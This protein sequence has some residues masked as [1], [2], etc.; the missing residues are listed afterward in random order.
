L[1]FLTVNIGFVIV[2]KYGSL[3]LSTDVPPDSH[4]VAVSVVAYVVAVFV[5]PYVIVVSYLS[6]T[7]AES[8]ILHL[9]LWS[10]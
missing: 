9:R 6:V 5:V 7:T 10:H 2:Q 3:T 1:A 8:E 4:V